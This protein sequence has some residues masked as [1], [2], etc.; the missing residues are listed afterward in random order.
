VLAAIRA[1]HPDPRSAI[2][3]R[4]RHERSSATSRFARHPAL[5]RRPAPA[6][7][8]HEDR[9]PAAVRRR[10][11]HAS[12]R[13]RGAARPGA[14]VG[15][16][17]RDARRRPAMRRAI[18]KLND[19]VVRSRQRAR[20]P[21]RPAGARRRRTSAWRCAGGSRHGVEHRHARSTVPER[22]PRAAAI[23]EEHV[24]GG[25]AQPERAAARHAAGAVELLSTHDQLL[26]GPSG[27]SYLGC[28][29][30]ADSGYA[31]RS[32]RRREDRR[33]ARARGVLG[34][35][36]VDFVVVRDAR[37]PGRRTR[38]S[39][40]CARAARRTRSSRCSS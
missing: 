38:S 37:G 18:V 27:Q 39:S 5:R 16:A 1:L 34:P 2:S 15:R 13:P 17:R 11:R 25:G 21:A 24:A 12:A 23:V 19:G 31:R 33:A 29:F 10:G 26:G 30:P 35:L 36:R 22:S 14:L 3:S 4:S 7:V 32:P 6:A 20:R 40:T 8:R 9:L 28:R